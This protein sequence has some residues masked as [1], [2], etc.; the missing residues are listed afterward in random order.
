MFTNFNG[1]GMVNYGESDPR[2]DGSYVTIEWFSLLFFPVWPV[3]RIRV[4]Q[5]LEQDLFT[6]TMRKGYKVIEE[7]PLSWKQVL[8]TYLF[9]LFSVSW[10]LCTLSCLFVYGDASF[11]VWLSNH[12]IYLVFF[13][14]LFL[15]LGV[16]GGIRSLSRGPTQA[17]RFQR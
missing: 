17:K 5:R 13:V 10:W 15:P 2:S 16:L 6:K 8:G 1:I 11:N 3:R 9:A 12:L 4:K 14:A 7:M